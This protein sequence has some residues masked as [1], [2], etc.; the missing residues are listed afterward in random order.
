MLINQNNNPPF[1]RATADRIISLLTEKKNESEKTGMSYR[2]QSFLMIAFLLILQIVLYARSLMRLSK[3][4]EKIREKSRAHKILR[5]LP[6]FIFA[7]VLVF[8]IPALLS[9]WLNKEATWNFIFECMPI[10]GIWLTASVFLSL[11]KALIKI[12]ILLQPNA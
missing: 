12:R 6:Q 5:I 4:Q 11:L 3:W 9:Q 1:Y 7:A 10:F 2:Y 8:V